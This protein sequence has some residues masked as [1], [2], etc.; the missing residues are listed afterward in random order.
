MRKR[1][2]T[3]DTTRTGL[4]RVRLTLP[5]HGRRTLGIYE[6]EAEA[7]RERAAALAIVEREVPDD[8]TTVGQYI[9]EWID[10]RDRNAKVRDPD[11]ERSWY[12]NHI[13]GTPLARLSLRAVRR[14]HVRVWLE[15]V[16][17]KVAR[18]SAMNALQVV[19][20]ALQQAVDDELVKV[21]PAAGVRLPRQKRT[22]EMWTFLTVEEQGRMIEAA[23]ALGPL[24]AFAIGTGLRA[25]E[26]CALRRADV[27]VDGPHP[28]VV[29]RYG[30][31][32]ERPTKAGRIRE[33]P[34][35]GL[36]LEAARAWLAF[37]PR[38]SSNP[39]GL[40]FPRQRGRYRD[41]AHV[42]KWAR[43][44]PP[45]KRPAPRAAEPTWKGLL[46][47]AGITRVF[48]WHDLRHTCASSLVS[49]SWGRAWSLVEVRDMLG[50]TSVTVT[51]R[52]AHLAGT[53][54]RRAAAE[55]GKWPQSATGES[56]VLSHLRDL[57]SR[58]TVYEVVGTDAKG[59]AESV[60]G[61]RLVAIATRLLRAVA[62]GDA[63]AADEA[64]AAL[65]ALVHGSR[66]WALEVAGAVLGARL[67]GAAGAR[68]AKGQ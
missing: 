64:Q 33:V 49:G 65:A 29:V 67:H 38:Y 4:Y 27:H 30:G 37:L 55:A 7:E 46:E 19:R 56:Q 36:A 16:R 8:T 44:A 32:P 47:A 60:A 28:R 26:L 39:L 53:A 5:G 40:M 9:D 3:I 11:S 34:L 63:P 41:E 18:Q 20:G 48:R 24:V 68:V 10:D 6:T 45:S 13:A 50:H 43:Y 21:N 2:G 42:L 52:Y 51:E 66:T 14:R 1:T 22:T 15:H 57:N 62:A 12:R 23:G 25:G 59:H 31:V 54:L 58:P 17:R 35:F 61:G